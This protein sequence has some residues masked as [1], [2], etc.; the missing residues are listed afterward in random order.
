[1][2]HESTQGSMLC[3][4]LMKFYETTSIYKT[5][6]L[7]AEKATGGHGVIDLF[8]SK[9]D[10]KILNLYT[11]LCPWLVHLLA[12]IPNFERLVS[13]CIIHDWLL[14]AGKC[15][16]LVCVICIRTFSSD[17]TSAWWILNIMEVLNAS[18]IWW[19]PMALKLNNK[20]DDVV[21]QSR[22]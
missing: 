16:Q 20:S 21:P 1:M 5:G 14:L 18:L 2:L 7:G 10:P 6:T 19:W 3:W 8:F 22:I 17:Y 9:N 11:S 4:N 12:T 13:F 15:G